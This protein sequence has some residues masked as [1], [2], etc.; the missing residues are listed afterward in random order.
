MGFFFFLTINYKPEFGPT[1]LLTDSS[2]CNLVGK[3][4]ELLNYLI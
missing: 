2:I 1:V 4:L 3:N